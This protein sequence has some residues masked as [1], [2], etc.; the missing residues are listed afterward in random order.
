MSRHNRRSVFVIVL[1]VAA[2]LAGIFQL[3]RLLARANHSHYKNYSAILSGLSIYAADHGSFPYDE[4]GSQFAL[5]KLQ[6]YGVPASTFESEANRE[7]RMPAFYDHELGALVGSDFVYLN[8]PGITHEKDAQRVV[9]CEK[10]GLHEHGWVVITA[11][12]STFIFKEKDVL[13]PGRDTPMG[14]WIPRKWQDVRVLSSEPAPDVQ[15]GDD[16]GAPY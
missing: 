3:L 11:G 8:E 9:I 6:Q 4:R 16:L 12:F 15:R 2:L 7:R 5:Y 1:V 13:P 14:L 10:S